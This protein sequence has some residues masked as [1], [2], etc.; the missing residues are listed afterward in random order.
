[1]GGRGT[2]ASGNNVPYT[3]KTIGTIDGIK[4]LV[5]LDPQ[6]RSSLPQEAH[7]SRGYISLNPRT[8][9]F[10]QYREYG[11]NKRVLFDIDY[12]KTSPNGPLILHWH[13]WD[14]NGIRSP[15]LPPTP[16]IIQKF[17]DIMKG[18]KQWKDAR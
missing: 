11:D 12:H 7:S 16:E 5:A 17:E 14:E 4:V 13:T 3:Y 9:D 2:Y 1:M 15:E 10:E 6:R 18:F 8:G